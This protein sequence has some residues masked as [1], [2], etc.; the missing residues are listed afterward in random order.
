MEQVIG[1]GQFA[2]GVT[3]KGER[4]VLG[5]NAMPIVHHADE[6][7]AALLDVDIDP[8]AAGIDRVLQQFL[9]HT[10]RPLNH[11]A[12]GDFRDNG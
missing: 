12:G 3:G 6:L 5:N 9:D 7:G 11:L 8:R 1:T 4:Q 10:R 2:G